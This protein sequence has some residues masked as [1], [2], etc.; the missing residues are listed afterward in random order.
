MQFAQLAG[1]KAISA[2]PDPDPQ[3]C[4]DLQALCEEYDVNLA[5]HNH[6]KKHRLGSIASLEDLFGRTS[7]RFGLCLDTAWMLD[8]GEDPFEAI[9]RFSGRLY[10]VHLKDF[11]YDADGSRH[12]VIIGEGGLDLPHLM[13]TLADMNYQGYLSL[14]YEGDADNP[15]P[16]VLKCVEAV[17]AA[18]AG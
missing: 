16:N 18:I 17:R 15:L 5:V 8:A 4:A 9:E 6:G 13:R 7:R 1:L 3:V 11:G 14:E 12:D 10:G 2:D